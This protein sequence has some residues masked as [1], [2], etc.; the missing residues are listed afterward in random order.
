MRDTVSEILREIAL[1]DNITDEIFEV[2]NQIVDFETNLSRVTYNIY[3]WL[4]TMLC[5]LLLNFII[6]TCILFQIL[7][8]NDDGKAISLKDLYTMWPDV[9]VCMICP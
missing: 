3:Q 5:A 9:S 4:F 1:L 6:V 2:A 8:H 7:V